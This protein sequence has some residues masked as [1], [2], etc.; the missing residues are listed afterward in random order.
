MNLSAVNET[1]LLLERLIPA[2]PEILFRFW[3]E[4]AQ[5]VRW[6]APDGYVAAFDALDARPGGRW[7]VV[8]SNPD[9]QSLAVSG[10]YRTVEPPNRL[11]FTWAWDDEHGAR[12]HESEIVVTI[13]ATPGGSRLM[14]LQTRFESRRARDGHDA[15]WSAAFARLTKIAG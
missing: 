12:G 15:G 2:P 13:E 3:T 4:P 11:A 8:Y 1:T 5:L 6:W 10:V 7:R 9:G 14:L